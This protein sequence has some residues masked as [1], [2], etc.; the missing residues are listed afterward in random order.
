MNM[1]Y[2]LCYTY[3]LLSIPYILIM[4]LIDSFVIGIDYYSGMIW[5]RTE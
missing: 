1:I 5:V 2:D 3:I 4:L